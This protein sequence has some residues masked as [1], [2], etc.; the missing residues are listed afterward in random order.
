MWFTL[1]QDCCNNL[2]SYMPDALLT[3]RHTGTQTDRL[4]DTQTETNMIMMIIDLMGMPNPTPMFMMFIDVMGMANPT[5]THTLTHTESGLQG[6][7]PNDKH[8]LENNLQMARRPSL[9]AP[10]SD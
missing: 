8:F 9:A 2:S 6:D 4:T 10:A 1:R 3:H 5:D 7:I